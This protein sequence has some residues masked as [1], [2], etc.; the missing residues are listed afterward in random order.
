VVKKFVAVLLALALACGSTLM[1]S[2]QEMRQI[3]TVSAAGYDAMTKTVGTIG[4]LVGQPD[5]VKT[6]EAQMAAASS[7][8]AAVDKSKPW[9]AVVKCD[10]KGE[11]FVVQGF[12]PI[13]NFKDAV[14]AIP[15]APPLAEEDGLLKIDTP[16]GQSVY[17]KQVD[18]WVVLSNDKASLAKTPAD[19]VKELKG[20]DAKYLVAAEVSVKSMPQPLKQKGADFLKMLQPMLSM[21]QGNESDE[22]VAMRAKMF[23]QAI[24]QLETLAN[25]IDT[26]LVGLKFEEPANSIKL[27]FSITAVPDS[28]TAKKLA[29]QES[30][31]NLA[32]LI[33]PD[34]VV[35]LSGASKVDPEDAEQI[36]GQMAMLKA[37]LMTELG[38]QPLPEE[39]A[40]VAKQIVGD[41][42]D[43]LEK[44]VALPKQDVAFSLKLDAN[45][46]VL[47][48]GMQLAEGAK[49]EA[50]LKTLVDQLAKEDKDAA[51]MVK[52]NAEQHAGARLH[53]LSIPIAKLGIPEG[54]KEKAVKTLGDPIQV[55]LGVSDS[56]LYIAAGKDATTILKSA[57]DSSKTQAD[58]AT[59]PMQLVV[60]AGPIVKFALAVA[61]DGP[62]KMIA[63]G[64]AKALESSSGKDQIKITA[65]VI[66]NGSQ[67]EVEVQ[68]GILKLI[69][70]VAKIRKGGP[71]M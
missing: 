37:K 13:K 28:K 30:K 67:G 49:L 38:G 2:A 41:L 9:G 5:V 64:I 61:P 12:L 11:K 34:A 43:V 51:A 23:E 45:G 6:M 24:K 57:I 59:S 40:K 31:T 17:L 7:L 56:H 20:L 18:A 29:A 53:V 10:D 3:V 65:T 62:P 21:K 47:L 69:G 70:A 50:T 35:S 26:V 4:N 27:S 1:C 68:E 46:S 44:S 14:K 22:Q 60:K 63:E 52:L 54:E 16:N 48:A 39:Q 55:V 71:G 66:P 25:E 58:K 19:P 8:L 33:L 32:G 42:F 15:G 36:K